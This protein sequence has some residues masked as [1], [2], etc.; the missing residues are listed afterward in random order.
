MYTM[1]DVCD[2]YHM[3]YETLRFYC[4][5]GLIPN[6]KRDQNNYRIFNERD[7]AWINGVQCLRKCGL[8][9]KD[10]KV[11]LNLVYQGESSIP[12]RKLILDKQ[13]EELLAKK[14]EI[15]SSIAYIDNKQK[16]YDD[17]LSGK[18]EYRSNLNSGN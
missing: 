8:S 17:V 7:L 4:N 14:D 16:Y 15:E 6:I 12:E 1:K 10:L 5:E 13:R 2:M 3:P 18:I 9:I 11:Y